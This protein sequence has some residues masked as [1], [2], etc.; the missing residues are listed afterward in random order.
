MT[1]SKPYAQTSDLDFVIRL[2][3]QSS[4]LDSWSKDDVL[5]LPRMLLIQCLVVIVIIIIIYF[6]YHSFMR[7]LVYACAH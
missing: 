1:R 2:L 6:R 4:Y 7:L 5:L 3:V